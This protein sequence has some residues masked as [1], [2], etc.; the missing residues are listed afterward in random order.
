MELL[1]LITSQILFSLTRTLNIRYVSENN[2]KLV[3]M[4]GIII[5]TTWL[6]SSAIGINSVINEN[7]TNAI[8]YIIT[9]L[10]GDYLGMK[11]KL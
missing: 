11:I 5:K 9:G 4:T 7:W 8:I 1:T 2:I 3:I 6:I 10:F